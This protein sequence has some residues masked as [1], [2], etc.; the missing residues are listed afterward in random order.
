MVKNF[1]VNTPLCFSPTA[2]VA[3]ST[4]FHRRVG[5]Q[6]PGGAAARLHSLQ[7]Q[8][9]GAMVA[10][11][12]LS[13]LTKLGLAGYAQ[14]FEDE[15]IHEVALLESMGEEML[16]ESMVELEMKATDVD[17]LAKA[18]FGG[19]SQS[20]Q[21][22]VARDMELRGDET[23]DDDDD[24]GLA[25]EGNDEEDD[26]DGVVIEGNGESAGDMEGLTLEDN[27]VQIEALTMPIDPPAPPPAAAPTVSASSQR[28]AERVK[29]QGNDML[30]QGNFKEAVNLYSQAI[31]LDPTN[32][33]YYSNRSTAYGSF[34]HWEKALSDAKRAVALKP[35][36]AKAH[37]RVG[38]ASSEL[39]KHAEAK[40]AY[41]AALSC[42]PENK[43][44]KALLQAAVE[45]MQL[46]ADLATESF[47]W[48]QEV[49]ERVPPNP[50]YEQG[51]QQRD[52]A[53]MT[54]DYR[55]AMQQA[56]EDVSE[57]EGKPVMRSPKG[58]AIVVQEIAGT[59]FE[60]I[61][62]VGKRTGGGAGGASPA[63][64]SLAGLQVAVKL[65][66]MKRDWRDEGDDDNAY[67][68]RM[69]R[70]AGADH[71]RIKQLSGCKHWLQLAADLANEKEA[72]IGGA[73]YPAIYLEHFPGKD[74]T[75]ALPITRPPPKAE[76]AAKEDRKGGGGGDSDSDSDFD[77]DEDGESRGG[78]NEAE[79]IKAFEQARARYTPEQLH[80]E[81]ELIKT[82]AMGTLRGM[83]EAHGQ[84]FR[85]EPDGSEG[86]FLGDVLFLD[87]KVKLVD[88]EP[89]GEYDEGED[90]RFTA[91]PLVYSP[92]GEYIRAWWSGAS[93]KI[94]MKMG[95]R[96]GDERYAKVLD[97]Y[98]TL[99]WLLFKWPPE[100]LHGDEIIHLLVHG[101][102]AQTPAQVDPS[103]ERHWE[104][105]MRR[106]LVMMG[107]RRFDELKEMNDL[108]NRNEITGSDLMARARYCFGRDFEG[109]YE[110]YLLIL[111]KLGVKLT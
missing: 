38:A 81:L 21:T 111:K 37:L 48:L 25:L 19:A 2:P 56:I 7:R 104:D 3:H 69:A 18:L 40:V 51:L 22:A 39:R 63:L 85:F 61:V 26:D 105:F 84:G 79:M 99:N 89:L 62:C 70:R 72:V 5:E 67:T 91:E 52:D 60:K 14:T 101:P 102:Q 23:D 36:W 30:K 66:H 110:E 42:E 68:E 93:A 107:P 82:V 16:R 49:N 77:F 94:G 47:D 109:L 90:Q 32:S 53:P 46:E 44:I 17:T 76:A 11:D 28:A 12:L 8:L 73:S 13:F 75:E 78:S 80:K 6:V 33:V 100:Q 55:N 71:T 41:E 58:A 9:T 83:K 54:V 103:L 59:N 97:N 27:P 95:E 10:G 65:W 108:L 88:T 1:T 34:G 45:T 20:A 96:C 64:K 29:V 24:D 4:C 31:G 43:Q 50:F 35:D 106:A 74:L 57:E 15:E 86:P 98:G 87:G 92:V